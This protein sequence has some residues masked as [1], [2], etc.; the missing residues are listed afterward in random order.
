MTQEEIN[1]FIVGKKLTSQYEM[2]KEMEHE[3][4]L[5]FD[6]LNDRLT[7]EVLK[8][9]TDEMIAHRMKDVVIEENPITKTTRFKLELFV[10]NREELK[11]LLKNK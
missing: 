2:N 10:F 6:N 7:H 8:R 1:S 3:L 5:V 9:F 11:T 4:S